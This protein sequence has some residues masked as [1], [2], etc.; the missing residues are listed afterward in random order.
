MHVHMGCIAC[1]KRLS[2]ED[3][4]MPLLTYMQLLICRVT[5]I[6][7]LWL[8]WLSSMVSHLLAQYSLV[9]TKSFFPGSDKFS[10]FDLVALTIIDSLPQKMS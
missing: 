10:A 8:R 7:S 1:S 5:F 2:E 6:V 4:H 9:I 3:M